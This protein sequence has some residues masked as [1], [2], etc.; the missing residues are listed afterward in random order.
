M[1]FMG[2]LAGAYG[3]FCTA[4]GVY[5]LVVTRCFGRWNSLPEK[6]KGMARAAWLALAL[7]ALVGALVGMLALVN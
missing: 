4:V 2:I 6:D 1:F 5:A 3:A 7:N